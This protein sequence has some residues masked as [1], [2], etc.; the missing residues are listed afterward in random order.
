MGT[1]LL[2][3]SGAIE[4]RYYDA[5]I[6]KI[7]ELGPYIILAPGLAMPHARPEEGVKR[8]AFALVT[9][10]EPVYFEGESE[11][12]SVFITLAGSDNDEHMRG[13][14]DITQLVEDSNPNS[15][16]GVDLEAL[17]ACQNED[18]VYRLIE[19]KVGA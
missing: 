3:A 16:T 13:I 14:V 7:N 12:V 5:I 4:A 15:E 11:G 8:T 2:L 18:D 1:D 9:L 17:L 10:K 19:Q 6:H